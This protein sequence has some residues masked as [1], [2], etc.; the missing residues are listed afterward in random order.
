MNRFKVLTCWHSNTE[1]PPNYNLSVPSKFC[2]TPFHDLHRLQPS[3]NTCLPVFPA[4]CHPYDWYHPCL[5]SDPNPALSI[6]AYHLHLWY[7]SLWRYMIDFRM[8]L[9]ETKY[10]R[11]S[12]ILTSIFN[13][14]YHI[15]DWQVPVHAGVTVSN[16]ER[17]LY[18]RGHGDTSVT[19]KVGGHVRRSFL[20]VTQLWRTES[21]LL[22]FQVLWQSVDSLRSGIT[23]KG[24]YVQLFFI[25]SLFT[26]LQMFQLF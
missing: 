12:V 4:I 14:F 23:C 26:S 20:L 19:Q 21:H 17:L 24:I 7:H 18:L 11:K 16:M 5:Q 15:P 22:L 10:S 9:R 25:N 8:L 6:Y 13:C 1:S 2:I 3:L